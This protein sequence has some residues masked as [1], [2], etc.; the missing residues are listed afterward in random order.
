MSKKGILKDELLWPSDMA[1]K[2]HSGFSDDEIESLC[3]WGLRGY[4]RKLPYK[5]PQW[6]YWPAELYSF[7]RCYREWLG[8]PSWFPLP[9]YGDHGVAASGELSSHEKISKPKVHLTWFKGRAESLKKNSSSKK[10]LHIP[11]PWVTFRHRHGFKKKKNAC[12]TLVFFSHSN[13]GIEIVDYDF[14]KYF[15]DLKLLPDEYHPLVICMHRHD[16]EKKY[17]LKMRKYGL[18]IISAG[19]TSSPYFVERFYNMI[20]N[21]NF[22]TSNSGGSELFYCEEFGVPYFIK[23]EQPTYVNFWHQEAPLGPL[24]NTDEMNKNTTFEKIALFSIFPP[25]N[26]GE[27]ERFVSDILGLD[28]DVDYAK[29]E[30]KKLLL[31]EYARHIPEVM[32]RL[33][34]SVILWILPFRFKVLLR[35]LRSNFSRILR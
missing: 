26:S 12:G 27:K 13:D 20:S 29:K 6:L 1:E 14:E 23:G 30:L 5:S 22:A 15:S 16:V 35:S 34:Q 3:D 2:I 9:L 28:V 8:L 7:G 19:E 32:F 33:T 10:I 24:K 18:P 31:V 17:H 25:I 21:F 11:H 4:D